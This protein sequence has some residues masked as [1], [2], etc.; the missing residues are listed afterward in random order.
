MTTRILVTLPLPPRALSPNGRAHWA[1]VRKHKAAQKKS[2]WTQ[3]FL[4]IRAY[5]G[6]LAPRWDRARVRTTYYVRDKRGMKRDA[7]NALASLKAAFDG[8]AEAGVVENDR[9]FEYAPV[10][11]AIDRDDPRVD[12]IVLPVIE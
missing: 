11:F 6:S 1:T 9:V 4:A 3:A 7:D 8:I 12:I 2:A 5:Y 10:E